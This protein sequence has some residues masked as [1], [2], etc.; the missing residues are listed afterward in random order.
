MSRL[1]GTIFSIRRWYGIQAQ[2]RNSGWSVSMLIA[3]PQIAHGE[4]ALGLAAE[5]TLPEPRHELARQVIGQPDGALAQDID[6]AGGEADL[7][8]QLAQSGVARALARVDPALRHLPGV[9]RVVDALSGKDQAM[10]VQQHHANAG[11]VGQRLDLAFGQAHRTADGRRQATGART[12]TA[13]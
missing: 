2:L 1:K 10:A 5:A 8:G 12:L 9:G 7:L 3:S 13:S 4:P 6:P 11:P